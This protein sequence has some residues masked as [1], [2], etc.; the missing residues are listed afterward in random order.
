M[1]QTPGGHRGPNWR[2]QPRSEAVNEILGTPPSWLVRSGNIL[3]LVGAVFILWLGMAYRYPDV[4]ESKLTLTTVDPARR[5]A[6]PENLT[7]SRILVSN[8]DT[9]EGGTTIMV[10][11]SQANFRD[12]Q[13]LEDELLS[14]RNA[15]DSA[16]ADVRIPN[17]LELGNVK[18]FL[19]DFEEK[20][21]AYRAARDKRLIGLGVQELERR[22]RQQQRSLQSEI[23]QLRSLE[24]ELLLAQQ[25]LETQKNLFNNGIIEAAELRQ[26]EAKE[27]EAGRILRTSE[28]SIRNYRF[29]IEL[30]NNQIAAEQN[31]EENEVIVSARDLRASFDRL[32][33][34]VGKWKQENLLVAPKAGIIMIDVDAREQQRFT[35]GDVLA[36]LLPID[37]QG[38]KGRIDLPLKGSGKVSVG[39]EVIIKFLNYPSEEFGSVKGVIES[40][41]PIPSGDVIPILVGLPNGMVTNT[42]NRLE[43]VQF[44]RGDAEII[45][46]EKRV[47]EWLLAKDR[48]AGSTGG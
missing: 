24:N 36:T 11:Q 20:R 29:N 23:N 37:P 10:F 17:S 16:L 25:N 45:V 22:I 40:K 30:I 42:G 4:V 1:D 38:V 7:I 19:Y 34:A 43:A 21:E 32:A 3:L 46:G 44:M 18:E 33:Q 47:L 13:F 2:Y 9:I 14:V 28:G 6:A 31:G 26:A 5:L 48:S 39:Q 15:S 35:E 8:E 41:S 12:L 27:A